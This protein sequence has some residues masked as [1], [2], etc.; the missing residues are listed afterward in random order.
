MPPS[1]QKYL[2]WD[3]RRFR[4]W[5]ENIGPNTARII[6]SIL[7][8]GEVEQQNYRSCMGI[9]K[10]AEKYSKSRLE[11]MCEKALIYALTPSYKTIK[12]LF[13]TIKD[14]PGKGYKQE[15]KKQ[16]HGII[17]GASFYKGRKS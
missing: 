6:D 10:L 13:T 17:R 3:G 11:E 8:T 4:K 14:E 16:S 15:L 7:N 12:N 9:L 1:H 5:A 2:E